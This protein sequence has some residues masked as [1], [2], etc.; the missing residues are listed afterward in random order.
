MS[1]PW[2]RKASESIP[3]SILSDTDKISGKDRGLFNVKLCQNEEFV[4]W[5][6]ILGFDLV[7]VLHDILSARPWAILQWVSSC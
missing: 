7:M 3:S 1:P 5:N 2:R 6:C 4:V